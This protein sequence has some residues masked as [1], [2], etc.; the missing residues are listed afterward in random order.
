MQNPDIVIS[1][2]KEARYLTVES[3]GDAP[4]REVNRL[5][6]QGWRVVN[7]AVLTWIDE[8]NCQRPWFFVTLLR[9]EQPK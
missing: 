5:L 9:G 3:V 1:E 7:V 4:D 8:F 6:K 2:P